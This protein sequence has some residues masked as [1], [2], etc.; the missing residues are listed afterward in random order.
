MP[1]HW[2]QNPIHS[3]LAYRILVVRPHAY[4][5]LATTAVWQIQF[6]AA[7]STMM[8]QEIHT[9]TAKFYMVETIH[10][11]CLVHFTGKNLSL[12]LTGNPCF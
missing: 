6:H 7:L 9:Y 2:W 1:R 4:L 10:R 3:A 5:I 12:D 11:V 8:K